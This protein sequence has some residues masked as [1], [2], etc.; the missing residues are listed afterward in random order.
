MPPTR[1][2][3]VI[4]IREAGDQAQSAL[5]EVLSHYWYPLY[6]WARRSGK[7]EE[8]AADAV[9]SF[10]AAAVGTNLLAQAR[11]ERGRLRSWLLKCFQ[12]H[13]I[14]EHTRAMAQKRGGGIPHIHVD[15]AGAEELYRS[16]PGLA[17]TADA[18]YV[19]TWAV[20]LMEEALLQLERYYQAQGKGDLY[21]AIL[22]ALESPLPD[23]TYAELAEV[24]GTGA[25]ALRS[26]TQRMR[27][28]YRDLLLSLAAERL[29]T[30]CEAALKEELRD[31]LSG[32]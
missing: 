15:W 12:R 22:P 13:L 28:R 3:L 14:T 11:E 16:E 4:R 30:T 21:A 24:L 26:A 32:G 2:S 1:W 8:D 5:G 7:S 6:S 10:L 27:S 9:Q 31:L 25:N 20:S 18:L 29:G 23:A 17:L 19:R